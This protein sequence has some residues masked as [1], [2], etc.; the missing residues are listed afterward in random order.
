MA[1]C[2]HGSCT[3]TP[4]RE[5]AKVA[6]GSGVRTLIDA[7]LEGHARLGT[8]VAVFAEAHA[9]ESLPRQLTAA[10]QLIPLSAPG[11]GEQYAFEVDLDACSGCKA[12]VAACHSLNG[13]DETETWRD[14]GLI[15]GER[16]GLPYQQTITSAC[17]HCAEPGCLEGCP[18]LAYEKD[19]LTGIVR[20]LD[21]QCI[22]CQYCILK[23]P[24]DVPKYNERLGVVRKCDMCHQRLAV[25]EAP[26]C[27]QACPTHAIRIVTVGK[28]KGPADTLD[29]LEAAPDASLTLPS[30]RYVGTRPPS[31]ARAGDHFQPRPQHG[32]PSLVAMLVL[33]Q[34]GYGLLCAARLEGR[35]P[36]S[37]E[38]LLGLGLLGL[39][40]LASITHLGR[41][42]RAWRIF[43]GLRSSWLS[44]EAVLL[45]TSFGLLVSA[46]LLPQ[47]KGALHPTSLLGPLLNLAGLLSGLAGVLCSVM[48]YAD[49]RRPAWKVRRGL[50]RMGGTWLLFLVLPFSPVLVAGLVLAKGFLEFL[51][52]LPSARRSHEDTMAA[53]L[54]HGP[55]RS[56]ANARCLLALAAAAGCLVGPL[57]LAFVLLLAGELVERH[58]FF[59][60]VH[61]PRMPGMPAT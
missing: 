34:A 51:P 48:I 42:L 9:S 11:P 7:Y 22:G 26:A 56:Y 29:F 41:P 21:D 20:H 49:T 1:S 46:C 55:L 32:H 47:A 23:C 5:T 17:H 50:L 31:Q 10:K 52:L 44:R 58:L 27:V 57:W 12:C 53:H 13:L 33:S 6:D 37:P 45:G 19:P 59:T 15:T 4:E 2:N 38:A 3:C 8:P 18:V 43:L 40:L 14:V 35:E 36:G 16:D 28:P 54:V 39:G 60:A 30:T 24:Y 25:G 61:A